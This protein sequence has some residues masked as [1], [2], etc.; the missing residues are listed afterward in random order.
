MMQVILRR[1]N[2]ALSDFNRNEIRFYGEGMNLRGSYSDA[3]FKLR[4][5]KC[6]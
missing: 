3:V 4:K 2:V 6:K 5:G 1:I